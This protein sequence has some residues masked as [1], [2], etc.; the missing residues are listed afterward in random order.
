LPDK[1]VGTYSSL[2][3]TSGAEIPQRIIFVPYHKTRPARIRKIKR[4]TMKQSAYFTPA[5]H[6]LIWGLLLVLPTVFLG[7]SVQT[8]LPPDYFLITNLYHIGLFYFNAYVLYPRLMNRKF[9]WLYFPAIAA[10][11]AASWFIK[12]FILRLA[13]PGFVCSDFK[14]RIIF[15]GPFPFLFASFIFRLVLNRMQG[16]RIKKEREA[17]RLATE[18]KF[19]RSQVSPHFLFNMMTNMVALARQKSDLLE[20]S[21]IKLSGLLRYMLYETEEK[22][23][24]LK[25]ECGY[26]ESYIEL[27]QLRFGE[28]AEI[29]FEREISVG[30]EDCL[31]EPMLLVPFVENAFKHGIGLVEK[32]FIRITLSAKGS[33]LFFSVTNNYNRSDMAKDRNS[34]IGLL[35]VRNRLKL[36]YPDK[37]TLNIVDNGEIYSVELNLNLTC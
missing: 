13:D 8:G 14:S 22:K 18:L 10:V 9:W 23:F 36:L 29:R 27:Q 12:I 19:L 25:K 17:Q 24:T 34:G 33:A 2:V 28:Q 20:P 16:E 31:I 21:L 6:F 37:Y 35:N 5:L 32:P 15:F 30:Q 1:D 11:L 4:M 7:G 3:Y 26:L